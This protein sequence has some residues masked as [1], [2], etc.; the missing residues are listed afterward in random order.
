M[1]SIQ[2]PVSSK[3]LSSHHSFI[4]VFIIYISDFIFPRPLMFP[5]ITRI[6]WPGFC[7]ASV[8]VWVLAQ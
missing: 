3:D 5:S 7:K 4:D 2:S 6:L 1:H 8:I